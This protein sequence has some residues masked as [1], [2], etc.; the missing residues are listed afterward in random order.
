MDILEAVL[1]LTLNI[2]HEG[3]SE[4]Q[5]DQIAIAHVTINRSRE[6]GRTIKQ[7][8][9]RNKQFSWTFQK[10]HNEYW[11]DDPKAFIECLDSALIALRGFDFT[12]GATHYHEKSVRP[13]WAK[14][15]K[16]IGQF[17]AHKFYKTRR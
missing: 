11:P 12:N 7:V 3:R 14:D 16:R 9:L 10:N 5:F 2:Y 8:V 4:D 15:M 13:Y 17:G 1:W 6:S